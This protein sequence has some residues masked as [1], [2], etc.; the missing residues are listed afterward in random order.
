MTQSSKSKI[1]KI[2]TI[3]FSFFLSF[4]LFLLSITAIIQYTLLNPDYMRDKLNK[5]HYYENAM[6]EVED[7]FSAYGSASGFSKQFFQT[8]LDINNV[9][10][11]V[12]QSL[13]SLYGVSNSSADTSS[14]EDKL[15]KQLENNARNRG[16]KITP[17]AQK[18][19]RLLVETCAST[20]LQY[21][22]IPYAKEIAPALQKL[23]KPIALLQFISLCFIILF[24]AFVYL[25]N[26]YRHR[27]IRA[28][29]YSIS[30][31]TLMLF[32]FPVVLLV[33]G[34]V[35]QIA[36]MSKSLYLFAVSYMNGIAWSFLLVALLF[37]LILLLLIFFYH[38]L[39]EKASVSN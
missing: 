18:G 32:V 28:Y 10:L 3:V 26:R 38:R 4:L 6:T 1:K 7:Q 36:L 39:K 29:I 14:F 37:A 22:S 8:V 13:S 33:S 21:I 15:T 27:A 16:L 30:G 31:T 12:N 5:S 23:K 19:I 35:N 2:I 9:Q 20:Y 25:L 17:D 24:T 34:K 11:N